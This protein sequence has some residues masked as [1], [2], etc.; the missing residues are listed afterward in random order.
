[1]GIKKIFTCVLIFIFTFN[2]VCFPGDK[3]YYKYEYSVVKDLITP[4]SE[5]DRQGRMG[6]AFFLKM[7]KRHEEIIRSK[8]LIEEDILYIIDRP[9]HVNENYPP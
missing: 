4:N 6:P 5:I 8:N 2:Q 1:M 3:L 7:Q 9:S